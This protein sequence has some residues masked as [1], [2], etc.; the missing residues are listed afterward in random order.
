[1]L[2]ARPCYH[3]HPEQGGRGDPGSPGVGSCDPWLWTSGRYSGEVVARLARAVQR[4]VAEGGH[5]GA[6]LIGHSGGGTLAM[7]LAERLPAVRAV[8]TLAGNLDV[9]AW[10]A[11]HGYAPLPDSLDPSRRPPLG[12]EVLQ[13]HLLGE[14]DRE[15][16]PGLTAA[17][18][19]RQPGAVRR[20][21]PDVSHARGWQ[22]VWPDVL[23]ELERRLELPR[24]EEPETRAPEAPGQN[25]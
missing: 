8:V 19:A 12:P 15:I 20:V 6:V 1:V 22:A 17:V 16:P 25:A 13:L 18:I 7:L 24:R 3:A 10:V 11:A 21:L 9:A 2:L 14:E 4:L 5:P 23:R